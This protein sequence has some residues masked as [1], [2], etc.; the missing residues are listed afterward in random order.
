MRHHSGELRLKLE[1]DLFM[2]R[3]QPGTELKEGDEVEIVRF[4][5]ITAIV[6]QP[7]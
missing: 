2:V 1:G 5:G 6:K 7:E 3:A 4:D